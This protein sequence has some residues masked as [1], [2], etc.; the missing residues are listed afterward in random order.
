[1]HIFKIH[2]QKKK[3]KKTEKKPDPNPESKI[4]SSLRRKILELAMVLSFC[5]KTIC[6]TDT[7]GNLFF[8][9]FSVLWLCSSP[10]N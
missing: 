6:E 3:K 5:D 4:L 9:N 10:V 8:N 1:M 7:E 2:W